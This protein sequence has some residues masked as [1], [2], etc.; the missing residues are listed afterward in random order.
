MAD[1]NP[2]VIIS[3]EDKTGPAIASAVAGFKSMGKSIGDLKNFAI[4]GVSAAGLVLAVK[5]VIDLGDEMNDLSQKVGINVK[6]LATWQLAANQSGT[7]IEGVAKGVKGLSKFMLENGD[8]LKSAGIDAQDAN[9]ALIQ[10]AD[11]FSSLPDGV[12]K[13]ALAVKIFGK[14]GMAMIPML[15][16]GSAGLK[17]AAEKS[18]AYGKKMEALAPLA[19]KFN[20]QMSE[21]ALQSKETAMSIAT[22]FLPGLTGIVTLLNDMKAGGDRAKTALEWLDEKIPLGFYLKWQDLNKAAALAGVGKDQSRRN[23]G[24]RIGGRGLSAAEEL[25]LGDTNEKAINAMRE[26]EKLL[27]KEKNDKESA[28]LASLRQQLTVATGDVSEYSKQLN[29]LNQ[30]AGKE[31]SASTREQA[32]ALAK[33]IDTLRQNHKALE[34]REKVLRKV[35]EAEGQAAKTVRNFGEKQ[36]QGVDDIAA[37][38]SALGKTPLEVKQ[39]EAAR[40]IEKA[41]EDAV[42]QVN[43][44]LGKIGDIE[45]ISQ[46]VGE[47]QRARDEAMTKTAAALDAEKT[48]QDALNA[49]WEYGAKESLRKYTDEVQNLALTVEQSLTRA[50]HGAEDALVQF[51]TTGKLNFSSLVTS[52]VADIARIQIRQQLIIPM[53]RSFGLGGGTASLASDGS[54]AFGAAGDAGTL[55]GFAGGG[56]TGSGPRSG[57]L[58]GQGGFMAVLHPN[59]T[60]IDHAR[61]GGMGVTVNIIG[62]PSAPQVSQR[63]DG[64]G[65]MT[66]DVIFERVDQFLAGNITSGRGAV[67]AAMAST[68]GVNRAAGAY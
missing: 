66:L 46:R 22:Y 39:I 15:N 54:Q 1:N 41:Y 37:R 58:D 59:E 52:I 14:E 7:S 13:T 10:L 64:N 61:G 30:G 19:D 3:A 8:A 55:L 67:P 49:S 12:Q 27:G 51:V 48:A 28:Y 25:A 6:D 63:P 35:A 26:A 56:Y 32:L 17:E 4:G 5:S 29:Y 31:F 2:K 62:A 68:Y 40:A 18:A 38:T 53:M 20:D 43:D 21:L 11:L 65:G 9:G 23:S 45:G 50:F 33:Q 47:L 42:R 57:G 16:L 34:D 60:V 24:G 44:E 36:Q